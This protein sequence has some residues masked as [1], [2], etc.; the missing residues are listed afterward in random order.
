MTQKE[1]SLRCQAEEARRFN[2]LTERKGGTFTK[3]TYTSDLYDSYDVK[4]LS[5]RTC[6][7]AEIKVR[8]YDLN[9]FKKYSP[10]IERVKLEGMIRERDR[11]L[12]ERGIRVSLFYFNF[13][14]D[15]FVQV[16]ELSEV[17]SY[18]WKKVQLPN[19]DYHRTPVWKEV[20]ELG[21]SFELVNIT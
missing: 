10:F 3:V 9:F 14:S 16:F 20:A 2:R 21:K 8:D 13:T 7:A 18:Q 19:D 17:K 4:M 1:N 5:G 6:V 15:G 12:S 11:I